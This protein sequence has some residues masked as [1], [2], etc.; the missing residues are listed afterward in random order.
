MGRVAQTDSGLAAATIATS[1]QL[2]QLA[3][4]AV[5][6]LVFASALDDAAPG[7]VGR[8]A[9]AFAAAVGGNVA[10]LGAAIVLAALVVRETLARTSREH[11]R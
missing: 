6:G 4:R 2:G 7:D 1:M 10:L 8:Y 3:G 11:R 9:H 5:I